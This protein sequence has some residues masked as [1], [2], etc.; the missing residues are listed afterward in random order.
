MATEDLKLCDICKHYN[1]DDTGTCKAFPEE[2]PSDIISCEF[3]HFEKHPDQADDT[4][5]DLVEDASD[6]V[7]EA[8]DSFLEIYKQYGNGGE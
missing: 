3:L 7:V 2:I 8:Y 4:T 6:D 1:G 5:F